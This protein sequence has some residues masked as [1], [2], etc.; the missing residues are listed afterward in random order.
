MFDGAIL[1]VALYPFFSNAPWPAI[2]IGVAF[3]L[4]FHYFAHATP[5]KYFFHLTVAPVSA[6][7]SVLRLALRDGFFVAAAVSTTPEVDS[8]FSLAVTGVAVVDLGCGL[9]RRDPPNRPRFCGGDR[10][11]GR[12]NSVTTSFA[13]RGVG[14][15]DSR[16]VSG[17]ATT[18]FTWDI[19]SG[20]PVVLD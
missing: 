16:V 2:A 7:F 13:Y 5:G 18:T 20:L 8:L 6:R 11:G 4:G 12:T 9:V 10:G 19:A 14:L 17:G 1:A 3:R 15:R